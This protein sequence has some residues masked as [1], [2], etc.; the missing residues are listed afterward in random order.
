MGLSDANRTLPQPRQRIALI[1]DD[2]LICE[3]IE[4]ILSSAGYEVVS[5]NHGDDAAAF[6]WE[7]QPDLL[8][9]DCALPGKSGMTLL[10]ELR[11]SP[12]FGKLP[13]VMLTGRRSGW[14]ESVA[15]R[16]GADAY[17]RKPFQPTDLLVSIA[18][19]LR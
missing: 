4:G 1:D 5:V 12:L 14:H 17:V 2:E 6:I 3:I 19:L 13:I 16:E 8:V 10:H 11:A 15:L 18:K 9:L 7:A